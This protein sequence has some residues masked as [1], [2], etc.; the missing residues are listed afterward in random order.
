[1]RTIIFFPLVL[2][3]MFSCSGNIEV[4]ATPDETSE[5]TTVTISP[6]Q[7][8]VMEIQTGAPQKMKMAHT[9]ETNGTLEL[10][11]QNRAT[12][13]TVMGGRVSNIRVTQGDHVKKGQLLATLE[14]P[15]YLQLQENYLTLLNQTEYLRKELERA[16]K[17][18]DQEINSEKSLAKIESDFNDAD[19]RLKG[20]TAQLKLIGT[21]LDQLE[22]GVL[23]NSIPVR[24]PIN[25]FIKTIS[26]NMGQYVD[27]TTMLFEIVDNEHLHIDLSVFEK[28]LA[29]VHEGQIV[30]FYTS[31]NPNDILLAKIF[32]VGKSFEPDMKAVKV[33]ADIMEKRDYLVP[34]M[35]VNG[36]IELDSLENF[37]LPTESI[38]EE[39][40]RYFVFY[41]VEGKERTFNKLEVGIGVSEGAKTA[42]LFIDPK[43]ASKMF[44]TKGAYYLNASLNQEE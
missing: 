29:Q 20:V 35:Y 10:P 6:E 12:L 9:V 19:F 42:V 4:P 26:I 14:N 15:E 17:L 30:H 43:D 7:M 34:G 22:K 27:P 8:S 38:V 28:D 41:A 37:V 36:H 2:L 23:Q 18:R 1:M 33:H 40:G 16:K 32:A 11:P 39:G 31:A 13:G 21:D 24:S 5:N 25:G 44:V 3:I